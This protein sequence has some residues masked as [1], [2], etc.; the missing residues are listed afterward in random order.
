M[1]IWRAMEWSDILY[2]V[3]PGIISGLIIYGIA[4]IMAPKQDRTT[5][6]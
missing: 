5:K 1:L 4:Y 6:A 3:A 2:E